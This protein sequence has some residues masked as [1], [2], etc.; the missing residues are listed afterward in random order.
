MCKHLFPRSIRLLIQRMILIQLLLPISLM[1]RIRL[2]IGIRIRYLGRMRM[3]YFRLLRVRNPL[4][5]DKLDMLVRPRLQGIIP[6]Q[7]VQIER[8]RA[9]L[10]SAS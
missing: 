6:L 7:P 4:F 8:E 3:S 10:G 9:A 2:E 1:K 5:R